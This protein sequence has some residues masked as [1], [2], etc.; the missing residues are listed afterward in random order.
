MNRRVKI[1]TPTQMPATFCLGGRIN[2][3]LDLR[4]CSGAM[5]VQRNPHKMEITNIQY[6]NR[7]TTKKHKPNKNLS[8]TIQFTSSVLPWIT[9][10]VKLSGKNGLITGI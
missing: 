3:V 5:F 2:S 4:Y 7:N 8:H 6:I 1:I 10:Y 9:V